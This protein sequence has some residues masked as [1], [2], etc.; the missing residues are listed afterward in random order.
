MN[1]LFAQL[2]ALVNPN[3]QSKFFYRDFTTLMGTKARVFSYNYASYSD[4]LQEG[5]LECRGILFEV[6]QDG[7][8]VRIM[9]RPMEKFFNL[10]E[11]PFTMNLDLSKV[12][13]G[14][15]KADGSLVSTFVDQDVLFMKSKTSV[16]SEQALA[17]N[18]ILNDIDHA[19]L[20][21]RALELAK[22]GYTLNFEYVAPDNRIVLPYEKKA[23]ILL[24][25]RHNDT[26]E[27]VSYNDIF[28]DAALRPY[29]VKIYDNLDS[30]V[31]VENIRAT[32][33]IEGYVFVMEDGL[34]FKLKTDWY[35]ALHRT[36]DSI[37]KNEALFEAVVTGASDDLR[38]L[39]AEDTW[40]LAKI[41]AFES[42]Y[43]DY[44]RTSIERLNTLYNELKGKDRKTYAVNGQQALSKTPFLF[45]VLMKAYATGIDSI[46]LVDNLADVFMRNY[47]VYVPEEY[48]KEVVEVQE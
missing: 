14:M 45:S 30:E 31:A 29:L 35:V 48:K 36:K 1:E 4:W 21:A 22:A 27:Y 19:A 23:L 2:M 39:F 16:S 9:S 25:I 47:K 24:N 34:K 12:A 15:D 32:E 7:N 6:D 13:Y 20:Q 33:G 8:A 11:T 43:L 44:L 42:V 26:G 5:A 3:D 46:A 37:T 40:A 18:G 28:A 17:A 41:Q 10:N 38:S